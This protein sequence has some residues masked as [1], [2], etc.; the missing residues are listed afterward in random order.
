MVTTT[1]DAS[2]IALP[3]R[4]PWT[5]SRPASS[6]AT[7]AC[8]TGFYEK[9]TGVDEGKKEGLGDRYRGCRSRVPPDLDAGRNEMTAD[10]NATPTPTRAQAEEAVSAMLDVANAKE[11]L[12]TRLKVAQYAAWRARFDGMRDSRASAGIANA[13]PFRGDEETVVVLADIPGFRDALVWAEGRWR[14]AIPVDEVEGPPVVYFG[15]GP[16]Q[17]APGGEAAFDAS[18]VPLKGMAHFKVDDYA[19]W[20]ELFRKMENSRVGSGMSNPSIFRGSEDGNDL[21]VL[22]DV[23]DA[24]KFRAWLIEDYMTGYPAVTGAGSGTYRFAVELGP[25]TGQGGTL[26]PGRP[27]RQ[28]SAAVSGTKFRE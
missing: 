12:A 11:N 25:R 26:V 15:T 13:K 8:L 28:H 22:G 24:A 9:A 10:G 17:E 20:H 2:R 27:A 7:S 18:Q 14:T 3:E 16:G 1:C 23:A 6:P 4:S 21:L 19:R 5:S